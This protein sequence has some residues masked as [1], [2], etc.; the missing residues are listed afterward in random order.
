MGAEAIFL[1]NSC[2]PKKSSTGC[3]LLK[4][5]FWLAVCSRRMS[6][7]KYRYLVLRRVDVAPLTRREAE[8]STKYPA[9]ASEITIHQQLSGVLIDPW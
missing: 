9:R 3:S 6:T 1:R 5:P 4:E 7:M 2:I 8:L